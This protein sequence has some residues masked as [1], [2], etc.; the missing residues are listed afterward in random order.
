M[1][2]L[3]ITFEKCKEH[4]NLLANIEEIKIWV[5]FYEDIENRLWRVSI[6]SEIIK[7]MM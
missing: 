7:S 5:S 4:V 3:G 1:K 6:R 2:K